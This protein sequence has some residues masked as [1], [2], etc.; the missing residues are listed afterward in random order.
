MTL[1]G[2]PLASAPMGAM[3]F[4]AGEEA[5]APVV[6]SVTVSPNAATGSL[7]F[8]ATVNG[9][10]NPSQ[11]VTWTLFPNLGTISA[12]GVFVE[13]PKTYQEQTILVRAR[14]V[15]DSNYS[16]TATVTIPALARPS[17]P[18]FVSLK[19]GRARRSRL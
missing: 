3:L 11:A 13:P 9:A 6:A 5:P 2:G 15:Q 4:S 1:L 8:T 12:S 19:K 14:S 7:T 18:F 10:G 17:A 16:G